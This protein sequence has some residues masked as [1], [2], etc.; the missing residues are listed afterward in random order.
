MQEPSAPLPHIVIL[1]TGG[2]IAAAAT[3]ATNTTDYHLVHSIEA[4]LAAVPAM[5][6]Y[7][8]V[9][10][11]QVVNLPS[12]EIDNTVLLLLARRIQSLLASDA[13]DGLVVTHGTDTM[14]ET[15]YF[16]N[17]VLKS[18][19]AVV[20]VG[21][22]RPS[23]AL[24]ADG[25]L[26]LLQAVQVA[27][28]PNAA[29]KGVL[30]V[31]AGRIGAARH[32][33][34]THTTATDAFSGQE[35]GCIGTV[36]GAVVDFHAEPLRMHTSG[37]EFDVSGIASLPAVDIVYGYQNA[38]THLIDAAIDAGAK[39]IVYAATG[40]GTLSEVTKRGAARAREQHVVF[41]R[42]TRVG[43]GSVSAHRFDAELDTVA[44]NS[45]NPQK[46][47]ILLTLAL[48]LTSDPR[49]IQTWFDRC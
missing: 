35:H 29:G 11:E 28:S 34:K 36:V 24:S 32:T 27:A 44:A 20:F 46:A 9:S 37:T 14:E 15:A 21:A 5:H 26:N 12:Q 19:K 22:M 40:N 8:R 3:A 13:V 39:G 43:G 41:V 17:L 38:G 18:R 30:V 33:V 16:L 23:T 2:T 6:A 31:L 4:V 42:S 47:R 48:T 45:L 25:S 1:G 49:R 10:A 7:A